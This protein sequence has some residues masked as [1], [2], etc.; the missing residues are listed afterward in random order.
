MDMENS[1]QPP[2]VLSLS[3]FLSYL[4]RWNKRKGKQINEY[5]LFLFFLSS[6]FG[7]LSNNNNTKPMKN[8]ALPFYY[9]PGLGVEE[10]VW[11]K[12]TPRK[13]YEW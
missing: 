7:F 10:N 4:R 6:S 3:F 2:W 13:Q 12:I 11:K 5:L 9:V 8:N 1:H